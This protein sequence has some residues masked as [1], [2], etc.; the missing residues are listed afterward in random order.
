MDFSEIMK[1]ASQLQDKMK[2]AK[3]NIENIKC[4]G[5]SGGGL[6]NLTVN[7]NGELKKIDID[8]G[9]KTSVYATKK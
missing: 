6:V 9:I 5:S 8:T 4:E 7:G 1:Q 3:E 2:S